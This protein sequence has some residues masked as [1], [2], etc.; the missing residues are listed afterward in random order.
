M[1]IWELFNIFLSTSDA[2]ISGIQSRDNFEARYIGLSFVVFHVQLNVLRLSALLAAA[3][4][5]DTVYSNQPLSS[6]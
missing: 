2:G 1:H 6:M 3:E 5:R 4:A